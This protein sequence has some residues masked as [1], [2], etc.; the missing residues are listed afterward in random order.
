MHRFAF[1]LPF[2]FV[3]FVSVSFRDFSLFNRLIS[4][5]NVFHFFPILQFVLLF[6]CI[7][8]IIIKY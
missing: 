6:G 3:V 2:G 8:S 4:A 5:K 7:Y 1:L